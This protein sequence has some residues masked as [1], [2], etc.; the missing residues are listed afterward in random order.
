M[1]HVNGSDDSVRRVIGQ[2]SMAMTTRK[3]QKSKNLNSA[4]PHQV[5][6]AR[7]SFKRPMVY[8]KPFWGFWEALKFRGSPGVF[9]NPE[10]S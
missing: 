6:H 2:V 4:H 7:P 1:L 3:F 10:P 9:R 8:P 5:Y